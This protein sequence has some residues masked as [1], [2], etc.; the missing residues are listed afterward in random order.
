MTRESQPSDAHLLMWV[1]WKL[2]VR[3]PITIDL[4]DAQACHRAFAARGGPALFTH[5]PGNSV[6]VRLTS[7]DEARQLREYHDSQSGTA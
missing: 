1:L 2:Q 3:E 4:A 6:E 7:H 5:G